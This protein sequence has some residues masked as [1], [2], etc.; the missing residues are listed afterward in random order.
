MKYIKKLVWFV[1]DCWRL[2]MD[3]RYNP[4]RFIGDPSIQFY[5]TMVL[6]IMWSAYFGILAWTYIGWDN[7]SIVSSIWIHM[8]VIIPIA[9]TNI[10]FREAEKNG[11]KWY[12]GWAKNKSHRMENE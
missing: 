9:I 6:F 5:F 3:N 10:T 8:A 4:L 7:Y 1:I 11:A 12:R 2:I